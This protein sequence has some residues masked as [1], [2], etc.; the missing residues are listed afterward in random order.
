MQRS[1]G[2]PLGMVGACSGPSGAPPV[3]PVAPDRCPCTMPPSTG[4]GVMPWPER[5]LLLDSFTT[6]VPIENSR[7]ASAR[8]G[9]VSVFARS[10]NV[11][12]AVGVCTD[13]IVQRKHRAVVCWGCLRFLFRPSIATVRHSDI[14]RAIP[15]WVPRLPKLRFGDRR[16]VR[17]L[18]MGW[19]VPSPLTMRIWVNSSARGWRRSGGLAWKGCCL[20]GDTWRLRDFF[21]DQARVLE[22]WL[23]STGSSLVRVQVYH[24]FHSVLRY[25]LT[26]LLKYIFPG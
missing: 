8:G 23:F 26:L 24:R 18:R 10:F 5:V 4:R 20:L 6:V 2:T 19:L 7:S 12:E 14:Y 9:V 16:R 15:T 21:D 22:L 1:G 11:L 17:L 25:Y 3:V 13:S